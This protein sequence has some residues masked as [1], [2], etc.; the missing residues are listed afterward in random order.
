M[1]QRSLPNYQGIGA[2]LRRVED[3]RFLTGRGRFVAD[4]E[5]PGALHC[6]LV[7][8]PH[9]HA[10]ICKIDTSAAAGAPGVVAVFTGADMAADGVGL[11]G[12]RAG[13]GDCLSHGLAAILPVVIAS[14]LFGLLVGVGFIFVIIPGVLV[15]LAFWLYVPAIVVEKRG[16]IESFKR[17]GFLTKG[18]RWTAVGLW[19]V[20]VIAS[21]AVSMLLTRLSVP[22]IG[23]SGST[24]VLYVWQA[25]ATAF[26]A[27]MTAVSYY[28]LR[29]DKEGVA[30]DEIAKVFD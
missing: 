3:R 30:I 22:A 27:V 25:V 16:I 12:Q 7:R 20:V 26:T 29:V 4:I 10:R 11:R 1:S 14:V 13:I 21:A 6:V 17:S 24:V 15:W 28:F 8:S 18:R 2:P 9:A 5:L 19:L 23:A